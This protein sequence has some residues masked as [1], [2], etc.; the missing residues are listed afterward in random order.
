MS[1]ISLWLFT[2]HTFISFLWR[3]QTQ[4][5]FKD[6]WEVWRGRANPSPTKTKPPPI[7]D[8]PAV[9]NTHFPELTSTK[10]LENQSALKYGL[11]I[12]KY[13]ELLQVERFRVKSPTREMKTLAPESNCFL[14]HLA[15][16]FPL[17][18]PPEVWILHTFPSCFSHSSS[19]MLLITDKGK[20]E[21]QEGEG[22]AWDKWNFERCS[23]H[24]FC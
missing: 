24:P 23:L 22:I 7:K 2:L 11:I 20:W 21:R 4:R 18:L 13:G 17:P 12:N 8:V 3:A 5:C 14:A 15:I 16:D 9:L 6:I 1:E 19:I 10:A